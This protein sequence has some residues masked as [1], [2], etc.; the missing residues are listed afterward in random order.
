MVEKKAPKVTGRWASRL[1]RLRDRRLMQFKK[2]VVSFVSAVETAAKIKMALDLTHLISLTIDKKQDNVMI[3]RH[4]KVDLALR[5]RTHSVFMS[6]LKVLSSFNVNGPRH[7][8]NI[9]TALPSNY[10]FALWNVLQSLYSHP[11]LISKVN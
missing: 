9:E 6:W 11:D 10:L 5:F 3:I 7:G 8:P 4:P 1:F 2:E